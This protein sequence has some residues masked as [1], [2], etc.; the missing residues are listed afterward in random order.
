MNR[1]YCTGDRQCDRTWSLCAPL[2]GCLASLGDGGYLL[3]EG[4]L[5]LLLCLPDSR[6]DGCVHKAMQGSQ[7]LV[8]RLGSGS[9]CWDLRLRRHG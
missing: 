9:C 7:C 3:S 8:G 6:V 4:S 5:Q 2:L 1:N